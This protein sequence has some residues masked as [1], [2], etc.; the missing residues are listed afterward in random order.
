[1]DH[2]SHPPIA[3]ARLDEDT[4]VESRG[5][6]TGKPVTFITAR[7]WKCRF[8]NYCEAGLAEPSRPKLSLPGLTSEQNDATSR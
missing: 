6:L 4:R 5:G 1:M 2:Q 7:L 3:A 8:G